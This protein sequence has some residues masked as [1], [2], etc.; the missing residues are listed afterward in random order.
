[1]IVIDAI[2]LKIIEAFW[3]SNP[4]TFIELAL[5]FALHCFIAL[6]ISINSYFV[7]K[8]RGDKF[9]EHECFY[10]FFTYFTDLFSFFWIDLVKIL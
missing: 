4:L 7:V 3:T 5:V 1:M 2:S 6:Y 10:A 9:Y 8:H